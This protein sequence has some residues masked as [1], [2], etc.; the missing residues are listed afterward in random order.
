MGIISVTRTKIPNIQ[1]IKYLESKFGYNIKY[2]FTQEH[3][4]N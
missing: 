2:G 1:E 4:K 3:K